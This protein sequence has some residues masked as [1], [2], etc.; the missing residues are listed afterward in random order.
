MSW[1]NIT[2]DAKILPGGGGS[3]D[4]IKFE[5]DK[6]VRVKLLL[7][8]EEQPYSYLEHAIEAEAVGA[9]GKTVRQFRTIR[10][11]KTTANPNAYCPIC[12]GQRFRRR[13]RNAANVWDYEQGKV[14][15]LNAG[16]GI[17][18]PIATTRKMGVDVLAVDWG[19][20]RTGTDRND[21]SYTATN[22]GASQFNGPVP[23]EQLFNIEAD[24][25]PHTIDEMKAIVESIGLT[26]DFVTTPPQLQYPTLQDALAH[27]MPNGRYKD[28]TFQQIWQAD[29]S[30]R[31][32]INFL[33]TKSDRITPE[34]A[35]AQV[36]LVNLGG[37]NIPGVPKYNADGSVANMTAAPAVNPTAPTPATTPSQAPVSHGT[38]GPVVTSP[39]QMN[40]VTPTPSSGPS[41]SATPTTPAPTTANADREAKINSINN[42]FSTKDKFVKG[43]F[44]LIMDTM[45]QAGNGKQ[46]ISDFTDAELDALLKLCEE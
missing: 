13:V 38:S 36:I 26:W 14:Q 44:K 7:R 29:Q 37:A 35:A 10:C 4:E 6:P 46:N 33:A 40:S 45:K 21:T 23:E 25:A 41:P 20:M 31:G 32:M 28:Q 11:T 5:A 34:K 27:V 17:W 39:I 42:L 1:D 12:E 18:K 2:G 9:D 43:G 15:K 8:P 16:D 3:I 24:Y 30:P 22:L 19:L